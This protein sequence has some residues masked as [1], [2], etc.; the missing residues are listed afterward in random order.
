MT[1]RAHPYLPGAQPRLLRPAAR[2]ASHQAAGARQRQRGQ[3]LISMMV[4]LIISLLTIAAMLVLYKTMIEVAGNASRAALR[5][6]QVSSALLA[7][8][9]ELQEAGFGIAGSEALDS[10]FAISTDGKQVTWRFKNE[11]GEPDQCAGLRL[12]DDAA[13]TAPARGFYSLAAKSCTTVSGITWSGTELRPIAS[14]AAFFEPMQKD[15]SAFA[16]G[17]REVGAL[18]LQPSS[19]DGFRFQSASDTCLPYRQDDAA[20]Q[21]GLRVSLRQDDQ[22]LFSVCLPNLATS[23]VS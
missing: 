16:A 3:T 1:S 18:T 20:S 14:D 8:Q 5:D 9:V 17:E 6:G 2:S 22:V 23:P 4:G 13:A 7:A 15:G 19:G 12:V 11:I 10:R 21:A